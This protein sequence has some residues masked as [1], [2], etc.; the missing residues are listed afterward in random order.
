MRY[1]WDTLVK[2]DWY[3]IISSKTDILW[4]ERFLERE[5]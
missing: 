5:I 2:L 1:G 3:E 4:D